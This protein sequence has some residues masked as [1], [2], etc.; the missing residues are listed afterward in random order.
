[1]DLAVSPVG[2]IEAFSDQGLQGRLL[3][4][5][6]DRQWSFARRSVAT[7]A[8]HLETPAERFALDVIAVAPGLTG[9]E[10]VACIG[11]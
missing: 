6:E 9:E 1:M 3:D 8:G 4:G 5:F 10:A 7:G 11:N 2:C